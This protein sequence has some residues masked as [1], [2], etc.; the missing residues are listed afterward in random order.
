LLPLGWAF[1]FQR[2]ARLPPPRGEAS[3][4][5]FFFPSPYSYLV[6]S[7]SRP[8]RTFTLLEKASIPF[9]VERLPPSLPPDG[10]TES[11]SPYDAGSFF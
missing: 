2:L 7:Y 3:F 11:D 8:T 1:S 5:S 4:L 6:S 9:E 10:L